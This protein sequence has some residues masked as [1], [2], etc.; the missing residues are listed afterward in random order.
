[1]KTKIFVANTDHY[2]VETPAPEGR[3]M[4][5]YYGDGGEFLEEDG[6]E[7]KELHVTCNEGYFC[8]DPDT[9]LNWSGVSTVEKLAE[10]VTYKT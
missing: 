3:N 4:R 5:D 1:M 6:D 8:G 9:D 7:W 10:G 2:D